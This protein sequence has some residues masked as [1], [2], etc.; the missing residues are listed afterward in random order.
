[1]K[2]LFFPVYF[3]LV[4]TFFIS[5]LVLEELSFTS[6]ESWEK[7]YSFNNQKALVN[8][9]NEVAKLSTVKNAENYLKK[10]FK[11]RSFAIEVLPISD[12]SI[13]EYI[14]SKLTYGDVY[15]SDQD[16]VY[17]TVYLKLKNSD[18]IFNIM[19]DDKSSFWQER[20]SKERLDA[21]LILL[22]LAIINFVVLFF[23]KYRLKILENTCEE[24]AC[25]NLL[26]RAK[27]GWFYDVGQLNNSLNVMAA[28][29]HQSNEYQKYLTRAIAHEI[30][31]PIFRIQCNL[32]MLDDSK[33]RSDQVNYF[34]GASDDLNELS[35]MVDELLNY[36]KVNSDLFT[37]EVE[38]VNL[39][40]TLEQLVKH[41]MFESKITL[42][43]ISK[44]EVTININSKLMNRAIS[45]II[46]NGV[47]YA[48][49]TV[50][51]TLTESENGVIVDIE[52][53]GMSINEKDYETIFKPF[54]RID[55]SRDRNSGGYG[56]GL[57]I[58][59]KIIE[60]HQGEIQLNESQLGGPRFRV[61]LPKLRV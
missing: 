51:V 24:L 1:M 42:K 2:K 13:P 53:D 38:S 39:T 4:V 44:S 58:A 28:K 54:S 31:T 33:I 25:G 48:K 47:R 11:D 15:I 56:L 5:A 36:E 57:S 26:T 10:A 3:V 7:E 6:L 30:R 23:V 8:I 52:N 55:A 32:D 60:Q 34:E 20:F 27:T 59:S 46:R 17:E 49:S 9:L 45:N 43:F 40:G 41:L 35:G 12:Q 61:L 21:F 18:I 19:A 16:I 29:L 37:L 22:I 14:L 50:L